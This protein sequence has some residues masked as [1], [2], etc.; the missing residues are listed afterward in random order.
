MIDTIKLSICI[1]TYNRVGFIKET[2]DSIFSQNS[3]QIE[4]VVLDGGSSD[5]TEELVKVYEEKYSNFRYIKMLAKGGFD[6]DISSAVSHAK[7]EYCWLF[8][9]DDIIKP[10]GIDYILSKLT[11]DHDVVIV[12]SEIK[13]QTL[14][15]VLKSKCINLSK[16]EVF[17]SESFEKF[18]IL[19]APHTSF[20][21]CVVIKRS[22]WDS[23]DKS[24]YFGTMF[25]HVGVL[26]QSRYD[27]DLLVIADPLVSIRYGNA[28]WTVRSFEISLLIWPKLIFGFNMFSNDAKQLV[29]R[30]NPWESIPRLL[31]YRA[32]GSYSEEQYNEFLVGRL[33][34]IKRALAYLIAIAPGRALNLIFYVYFYVCR[35]F[36]PNAKLILIDLEKSIYYSGFGFINRLIWKRK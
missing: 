34:F 9:D 1:A 19:T 26:F 11:Q 30:I 2:L 20:L 29:C 21:G 6:E 13:N 10:G 36:H 3:D 15:K 35:V 25:V 14:T 4:V 7:G 28:M 17:N 8:S 16:D 32:R 12:N 5:G 33:G 24:K 22:I 31:F 23:R 18:F 27:G